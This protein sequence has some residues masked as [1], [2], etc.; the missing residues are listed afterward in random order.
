[1]DEPFDGLDPTSQMTLKKILTNYNKANN[2]TIVLSSH[3]LNHVTELSKRIVLI[4]KGHIIQ[5]TIIT[6]STLLELENYFNVTNE[7]I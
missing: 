6:K 4:E 2:A 5:D 1:M 7:L 3:D